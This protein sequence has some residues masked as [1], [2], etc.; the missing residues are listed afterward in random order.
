MVRYSAT[1]TVVA[2]VMVAFTAACTTTPTSPSQ[3]AAPTEMTALQQLAVPVPAGIVAPSP[4]ALGA[5]RFV[6]FGDSITQGTQS[7]YDGRFL[8]DALPGAYPERLHLGLNAN[9]P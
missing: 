8:Y 7:S 1:R 6:A 3:S 9:Y 5:T 2:A 4:A